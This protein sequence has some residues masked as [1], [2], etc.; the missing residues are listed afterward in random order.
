[1]ESPYLAKERGQTTKEE[2]EGFGDGMI[3]SNDE[4]LGIILF[5][6][7]AQV[8]YHHRSLGARVII[9]DT[10]YIMYSF[11]MFL[12]FFCSAG[13]IWVFFWEGCDVGALS[14]VPSLCI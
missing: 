11:I 5:F 12:F 13:L 1:M 3:Y 6:S 9:Y 10:I 2:P 4:Y 14:M 7:A 8:T